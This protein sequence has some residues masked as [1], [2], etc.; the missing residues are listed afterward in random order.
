[1]DTPPA[2]CIVALF[3]V[4]CISAGCGRITQPD[5]V[6]LPATSACAPPVAI[7]VTATSA[8]GGPVPGLTYTSS[9]ALSNS[10][11]CQPAGTTTVCTIFGGQGTY[12]VLLTAPGFQDNTLSVTVTGTMPQCGCPII[13]TQQASVVLIPK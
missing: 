6:A 4:A 1:M 2:R 10:G 8:A 5:C 3:L 11:P 7:T 9:G 13:Q 12:N